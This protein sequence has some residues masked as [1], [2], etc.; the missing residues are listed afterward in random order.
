MQGNASLINSELE[1][2]HADK[3]QREQMLKRHSLI[4]IESFKKNM[5]MARPYTCRLN[6]LNSLDSLNKSTSVT[7]LYSIDRLQELTNCNKFVHISFNI[8][9]YI[10]SNF[11]VRNFKIQKNLKKI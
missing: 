7:L 3:E 6:D 8:C 2:A 1:F 5:T 11:L 9:V 10:Y 4:L